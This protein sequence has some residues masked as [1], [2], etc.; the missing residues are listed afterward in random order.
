MIAL[1]I[2]S[3]FFGFV[4]VGLYDKAARDHGKA[5]GKYILYVVVWCVLLSIAIAWASLA[6]WT[7]LPAAEIQG[8]WTGGIIG[9]FVG[10]GLSKWQISQETA[11][12]KAQQEAQQKIH[13]E[14]V[15]QHEQE[16]RERKAAEARQ[17]EIDAA[18]AER[19]RKEVEAEKVRLKAER[20]HAAAIKALHGHLELITNAVRAMRIDDPNAVLISTVDA[21]LRAIGGNPQIT[22]E[23]LADPEVREDVTLLV[24]MLDERGVTDK[25]LRNRMQKVLGLSSPVDASPRA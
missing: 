17:K 16:E 20:E 22:A 7:S 9:Y 6:S 21:E 4:W 25:I 12:R 14:K 23:M 11:E 18:D 8:L 10:L 15:A 1:V 2:S 24:E 19:R 5:L 13:L 3:I